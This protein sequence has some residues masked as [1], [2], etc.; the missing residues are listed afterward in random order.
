MNNFLKKDFKIVENRKYFFLVPI[1]IVLIALIFM[2]SFVLGNKDAMATFN[3]SMDFTGGYKMTVKLGE[4]IQDNNYNELVAQINDAFED[5][6]TEDGKEVNLKNVKITTQSSGNDKAF[7]VAYQKPSNVSEDEMDAVND[8]IST[9][10]EDS[11]FNI[12]PTVAIDS[13]AVTVSYDNL[14]ITDKTVSII[15]Q[16]LDDA[17]IEV[18]GNVAVVTNNGSY[19]EDGV[20]KFTFNLANSSTQQELVSALTIADLYAGR[21][22]NSGKVSG[23][24]SDAL[25]TSALGAVAF[26]VV[27]MFIYI[28]IRFRK[29]GVS[30]AIATIL[31]L[32]HDVIIMFCFMAIFRVELGSSFIAGLVTILGYSINNTIVIFDR[33]RENSTINLGKLK[34]AEIAN[35]SVKD[36]FWRS[37]NSTFTTL[38]VIVC[39]AILCV[40]DVQIFALPIIVGLIAGAYSSMVIAPSIWAVMQQAKQNK[41]RKALKSKKKA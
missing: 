16:H 7:V 15:K 6:E 9:R 18:N 3:F 23:S 40:T 32:L 37:V 8:I 28:V 25:V 20:V 2:A 1:V 5:I 22:I 4:K 31:A 33:V 12:V 13:Q 35:K 17:G 24:V 41:L 34:P 14:A 39:L 29:I 38:S 26:A 19:R 10:L 30:A 21:V 36:T 27:L 11:M